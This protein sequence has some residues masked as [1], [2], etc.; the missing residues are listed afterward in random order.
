MPS[1]RRRF[2]ARPKPQI[3]RPPAN[4]EIQMSEVRLIDAEGLPVGVVSSAEARQRA[5]DAGFDLVMVAEKAN[6]PVVRIM[7]LGK[8]M[9]EKRK[10]EAKQ[11]AKNKGGEIKGIRIG[12]KMGSHDLAIRLEQAEEF[13]NQG[14]KVKLEM[15]LHGREK[16]RVPM[17]EQRLR[18]FV[19]KVPGGAQFE[20][21]ISRTHNNLSAVLI[22]G[23][24][25]PGVSAPDD[26]P[27]DTPQIDNGATAS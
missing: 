25:A 19:A 10:K 21:V 6:P 8:H 17:A 1:R 4:D 20:D 2:R 9:Y 22:R 27:D 13:L 18:E 15:R 16:G 3:K 23:K 26:R 5:A 12:F 24:A 11:K 7:N 14:N